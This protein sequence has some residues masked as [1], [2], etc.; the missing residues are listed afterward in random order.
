MKRGKKLFIGLAGL[1]CCA[2]IG[3]GA[4]TVIQSQ[5][6]TPEITEEYKPTEQVLNAS[7]ILPIRSFTLNGETKQATTWLISP[8][9]EIYDD[10]KPVLD[11][12]GEWTVRF[13]VKFGDRV[14]HH[15]E[16][17]TVGKA[18]YEVTGGGSV[19]L[20]SSEQYARS[21]EGLILTM[22]NG[23]K[24]SYN[25]VID[26]STIGKLE[27]IIQYG[28]I[29]SQVGKSDI[30]NIT[31]TLTD[32]YNPDVWIKFIMDDPNASSSTIGYNSASCMR[33]TY[34]NAKGKE[35][36]LCSTD[37]WTNNTFGFG[38]YI[39]HSFYGEQ[40]YRD[41]L[42]SITY[43]E[44]KQVVHTNSKRW[45][46]SAIT[47]P[48]YSTLVAD[49][50]NNG[51]ENY[52]G[53]VL[54]AT[55]FEEP[56]EG[57]STNDVY[58]SLTCDGYNNPSTKIFIKSI[59]G[60][61]LTQRVSH[62]THKPMINVKLGN[63]K[64]DALPIAKVGMPYS[65]FDAV[66][67]DNE[68]KNIAVKKAVYL[69]NGKQK[70]TSVSLKNGQFT[71]TAE[72]VYGISYTATDGYG[73]TVEK[74]VNV[75]AVNEVKKPKASLVEG[76]DVEVFY[77][78]KIKLSGAIGTVYSGEETVIAEIRKGGIPLAIGVEEYL[79]TEIGKYRVAYTVR[80]YIGQETEVFYDVNV[81]YSKNPLLINKPIQPKGFIMG[82]SYALT[83]PEAHDYY[84]KQG[85]L[86][87]VAAKV[88]VDEGTGEKEIPNG[89]YTPN[90]DFSEVTLHFVYKTANGEA[91]VSYENIPVI[92]IDDLSVDMPK[93]FLTQ[94]GVRVEQV[95]DG[96]LAWFEKDSQI[97]FIKPIPV[98]TTAFGMS[99]Y[100]EKTGEE[101]VVYN[102]AKRVDVYLIDTL[103]ETK[104]IKISLF[105][106]NGNATF[107]VNDGHA[108]SVSGN[109][110][111]EAG[112]FYV[113]FNNLYGSV[114]CSPA[115][116]TV[117]TFTDG[118]EYIG[119]SNDRAYVKIAVNGVEQGERF[120]WKVKSIGE[121]PMAARKD[122]IPPIIS[123]NGIE[124]IAY[125]LNEKVKTFTAYATDVLCENIDVK[126]S[127]L[128]STYEPYTAT[129][130]TVLNMVDATK[131]Y[132]IQ[133]TEYGNYYIE[134]TAKDSNGVESIIQ[135]VYS[136]VDKESPALKLDGGDKSCKVGD[137]I[138]LP[139]ATFS[140]NVSEIYSVQAYVMYTDPSG[141]CFLIDCIA[142]DGKLTATY[143][144]N[145]VGKWK[146]SYYVYD[147]AYNVSKAEITVNVTK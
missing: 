107:S 46:S 94:E 130:G 49:L 140:D 122:F 87:T 112:L 127:V 115:A 129:D 96:V 83:A 6:A 74:V 15:E 55:P 44:E 142:E 65:V 99:V 70:L 84:T 86:Q 90:G 116:L 93:Y 134:Y 71:P 20:G 145:Q 64:E 61:D 56:F 102:R 34:S 119:F 29:T 40:D 91:R 63:Y 3:V 111:G 125:E 80:D 51:Y 89:V 17:F 7:F 79:P 69:M 110:L 77:G 141:R 60:A 59:A 54:D 105:N 66:A 22:P 45:V 132:E 33:V 42:S 135:L 37:F 50:G 97:E 48:D 24:F 117:K 113:S 31:L 26:L 58:L 98:K 16:S 18:T 72:G 78:E 35:L 147:E 88:Y 52:Y 123:V 21:G 57:F 120:G 19:A 4:T 128:T 68:L 106:D 8:S 62:D 13:A 27:S 5:A 32:A 36:G 41:F 121:Q 139:V 138:E 38:T 92:K 136:V 82:E 143:T 146:I 144:F 75:Q 28:N 101:T 10:P 131:P 39:E 126:M 114:K 108:E 47:L 12:A 14:Y 67:V 43:D 23:A 118:S 2:C 103:D 30:S 100:S 124:K 81:T 25:E 109:F 9:G 1:L 76:Y 85:E 104:R 53:F 137:T 133:L 11:E 95:E 73:N